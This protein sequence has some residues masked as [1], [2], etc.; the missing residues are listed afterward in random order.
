MSPTIRDP[1][2]TIDQDEANVSGTNM[3]GLKA[4]LFYTFNICLNTNSF[5]DPCNNPQL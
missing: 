1:L 3:K 4:H 5:K 2:Q